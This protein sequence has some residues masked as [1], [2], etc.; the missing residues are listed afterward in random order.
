MTLGI[1]TIYQWLENL[2]HEVKRDLKED[3]LPPSSKYKDSM[4]LILNNL[5][6][7]GV[8]IDYNLLQGNSYQMEDYTLL[9]DG[10]LVDYKDDDGGNQKDPRIS[11]PNQIFLDMELRFF[12]TPRIYNMSCE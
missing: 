4:N 11:P 7:I 2:Y 6:A 3:I 10:R 8:N 12:S 1:S 9:M 5:R